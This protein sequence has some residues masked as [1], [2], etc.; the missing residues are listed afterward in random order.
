MKIRLKISG[1]IVEVPNELANQLILGGFAELP[2][3]LP[4]KP[5]ENAIVKRKTE[6]RDV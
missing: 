5:K 6:K 3:D 4:A 2:D 1:R